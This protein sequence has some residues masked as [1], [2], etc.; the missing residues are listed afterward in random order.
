MGENEN[1]E[2][3]TEVEETKEAAPEAVV[4]EAEAASEGDQD[5]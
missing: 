4:D 5:A 1:Q 2:A 3:V